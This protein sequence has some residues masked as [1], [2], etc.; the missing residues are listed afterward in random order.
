MSG[1]NPDA[2][3]AGE[4]SDPANDDGERGDDQEG[5]GSDGMEV[6]GQSESDGDT[7]LPAAAALSDEGS[8]GEAA[9]TPASDRPRKRPASRPAPSRKPKGRTHRQDGNHASSQGKTLSREERKIQ[10]L[11]KLFQKQVACSMERTDVTQ[12]ARWLQS[13]AHPR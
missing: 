2:H 12:R 8:D 3:A 9:C 5:M 13:K 11:M 7:Q 1:E 4:A 10:A 6:E